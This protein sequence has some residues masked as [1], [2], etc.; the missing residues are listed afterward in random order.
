MVEAVRAWKERMRSAEGQAVYKERASTSE[1]A[2]ADVRCH[3]GLGP[4]VVR[5]LKKVRCVALWSAL[6]YT[7]MHFGAALVT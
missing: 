1:T 2:N 5:G 6:A 4:L 3:R 7:V